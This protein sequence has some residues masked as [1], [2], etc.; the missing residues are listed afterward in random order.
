M[1]DPQVDEVDLQ[2]NQISLR[3][4]DIHFYNV[5]SVSMIPLASDIYVYVCMREYL[6]GHM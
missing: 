5:S 3:A 6:S 2:M 1:V 4:S